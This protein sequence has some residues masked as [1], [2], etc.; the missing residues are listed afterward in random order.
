MAVTQTHRRRDM[1]DDPKKLMTAAENSL[2]LIAGY[3]KSSQDQIDYLKK[4]FEERK[5]PII[6]IRKSIEAVEGDANTYQKNVDAAEDNLKALQKLKD[7]TPDAT[8]LVKKLDGAVKDGNK[9]IK[10]LRNYLGIAEKV[11][12]DAQKFD[13][14][15]GDKLK[16]LLD[17]EEKVTKYLTVVL[18]SLPGRIDALQSSIDNGRAAD[19][20]KGEMVELG[21]YLKDFGAKITTADS[22]NSSLADAVKKEPL[23]YMPQVKDALQDAKKATDRLDKL[24]PASRKALSKSLTDLNGMSKAVL[25][26]A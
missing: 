6:N 10:E 25:K 8:K 2:K 14:E 9:A 18:K 19:Q 1:P 17:E 11:C 15:L 20:V 4:D 16:V 23:V 26:A 24:I 7:P 22:V 3:P 21:T 5:L 12:A 13:V